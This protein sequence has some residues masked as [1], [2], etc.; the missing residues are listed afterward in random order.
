VLWSQGWCRD[1]GIMG[2]GMVRRA[3][4]RGLWDD[5]GVVGMMVSPAQVGDIGGA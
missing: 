5:D 4:H 3:P 1:D 2:S